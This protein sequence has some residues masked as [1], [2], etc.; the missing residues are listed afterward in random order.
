[1]LGSLLFWTIR[2]LLSQKI[3]YTMLTSA[4]DYYN[5]SFGVFRNNNGD[6]DTD[7][8]K[9]YFYT[10]NNRSLN[11]NSYA[12]PTYPAVVFSQELGT[13]TDIEEVLSVE[14]V[15]NVAEVHGKYQS[16][17]RRSDSNRI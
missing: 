16:N 13:L 5:A 9:L 2:Y 17:R 15:F 8:V 11:N 12:D 4:S 6:N 14:E 1:M 3:I 10:G 7:G